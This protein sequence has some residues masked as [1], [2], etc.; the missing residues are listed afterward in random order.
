LQY[1]YEIIDKKNETIVKKF[2]KN[3]NFFVD[4]LKS[5]WYNTDNGLKNRSLR[6]A[7]KLYSSQ[8]YNTN[9]EKMVFGES[10]CLLLPAYRSPLTFFI[11]VRK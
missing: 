5:F 9:Q 3:L 2:S 11:E 7:G 6:Y 8:T 10:L 1:A 4:R